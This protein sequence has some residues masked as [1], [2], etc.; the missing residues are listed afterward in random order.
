MAFWDFLFDGHAWVGH[1][2]GQLGKAW[3]LAW[4]LWNSEHD[5]IRGMLNDGCLWIYLFCVCILEFAA[6][7]QRRQQSVQIQKRFWNMLFQGQ[8]DPAA[9]PCLQFPGFIRQ[10]VTC[11]DPAAIPDAKSHSLTLARL[12]VTFSLTIPVS[13]HKT[14]PAAATRGQREYDPD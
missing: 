13:L 9:L 6:T 1:M 11:T 14:S 10:H 12:F 7:A 2:E 3:V 4:R 5:S 8:C